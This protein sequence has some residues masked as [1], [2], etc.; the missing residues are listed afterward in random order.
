MMVLFQDKIIYMPSMPPYARREK[1]EDYTDGRGICNGVKWDEIKIKSADAIKLSVLVGR[2]ATGLPAP[3]SEIKQHNTRPKDVFI[4]YFQGNGSSLPPRLP[5]L[6][7]VLRSVNARSAILE[8]RTPSHSCTVRY[9]LLALAYR[10]YW[11][12]TGRATQSGIELDAQALLR[13]LTSTLV[14]HGVESE[15]VLWGQ[16][17]GGGVATTAAATYLTRHSE[18]ASKCPRITGMVLE[19]PFTS[20]KNM[21][22]A[23]YPQKW[24]PYRYLHPFLWNRWDSEVAVRRI[25]ALTITE[26]PRILLLPATR[27]EVVPPEDAGKLEALCKDVGLEVERNDVLGALHHEASLRKDGQEAIAKFVVSVTS[28]Q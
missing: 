5:S 3:E 6:S 23:L 14:Q 25:A 19:T 7:N 4:V 21:L 10:G 11:T 17:I 1:V 15:I 9:T 26:K 16:S 28:L 27:D 8:H 13:H 2:G 22:I 20:V 12:S 18:D 24:L